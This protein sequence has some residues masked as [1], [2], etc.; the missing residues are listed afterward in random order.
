MMA[1]R[2]SAKPGALA[3]TVGIGLAVRGLPAPTGA[4]PGAMSLLA[5][6]IATIAGLVLEPLPTGGV[7]F[8]ALTLAVITKTLTFQEAFGAF[9]NEVIWLIVLAVFFSRGFV[10][11]GLGNRVA[12][13][14]VS[15]FGGSSL[16]LGYGLALSE[17]LIAPAMPSTTARASIYVPLVNALA[18]QA[19]SYPLEQDPTGISAGRLG[20]F[21]SQCH[22]QTSVHSS[23]ATM[24]S[25]AQNLLGMKIAQ[26]MG[27]N[28]PGAFGVW[29]AA[30]CVPAAAGMLA[31]PAIVHALHPPTVKSTPG[32]CDDACARLDALGPL[33]RDERLVVATML[34]TVALWIF[35]EK[36][37]VAPAAAAMIGLAAQ[38]VLGVTTWPECARMSGAPCH[39]RSSPVGPTRSRNPEATNTSPPPRA[40]SSLRFSP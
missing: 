40:P 16:G 6:F 39:P 35:G 15:K 24:T 9:T 7:C 34:G 25:A 28:I 10:A 23:A 1:R 31:M 36:I 38:I 8:V 13:F 14:F 27:I 20:A 11:S 32:A 29:L 21:L 19:D 3:A 37:G 30:A 26:E 22:L 33:S 2:R 4:A 5:I 18:A 12:T 17:A